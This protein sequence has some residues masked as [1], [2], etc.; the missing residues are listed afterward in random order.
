MTLL[1]DGRVLAAGGSRALDYSWNDPSA[2]LNSVE[3]YDPASNTWT[4]VAGL[5]RAR[6]DHTAT[7]LSDGRVLITGG[8]GTGNVILD[9][10][11]IITPPAR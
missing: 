4:S 7:L 9:S 10:I 6:A 1:P 2:I 11:E 8:V 5:Q 3:I